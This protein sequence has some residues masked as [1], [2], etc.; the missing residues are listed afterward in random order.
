MYLPVPALSFLICEKPML[1]APGPVTGPVAP[2]QG[3]VANLA[4]SWFHLAWK[5][6][7]R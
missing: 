5:Q 2:S 4:G 7:M 1:E 6:L 3:H